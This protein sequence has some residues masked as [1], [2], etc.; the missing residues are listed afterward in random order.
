MFI[1]SQFINRI[2]TGLKTSEIFN[3]DMRWFCKLQPVLELWGEG[4]LTGEFDLVHCSLETLIRWSL[5]VLSFLWFHPL[6]LILPL[7]A[8]EAVSSLGR[9]LEAAAVT[10]VA[11]PDCPS[12][13][14]AEATPSRTEDS[15][16]CRGSCSQWTQGKQGLWD[17][18]SGQARYA[19]KE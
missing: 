1:W 11:V 6:V 5:G 16:F 13:C 3:K 14:V 8:T 18:P 15:T 4:L 9:G 17:K 7:E 12:P 10:A 2:E 19:S